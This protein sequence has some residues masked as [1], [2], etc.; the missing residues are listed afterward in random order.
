MSTIHTPTNL[1]NS[2]CII[3]GKFLVLHVDKQT[4]Q[5]L[6]ISGKHA[7]ARLL[8]DRIYICSID[9]T[10]LKWSSNLIQRVIEC[11]SHVFQFILFSIDSTYGNDLFLWK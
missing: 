3:Q 11:F 6:G 4:F 8:S 10:K 9:L 1:T 5:T 7:S 2:L